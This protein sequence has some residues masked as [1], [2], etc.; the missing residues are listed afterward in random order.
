MGGQL[1]FT[2][3]R[4]AALMVNHPY[5]PF[6][7]T[8]HVTVTPVAGMMLTFPSFLY[9]EVTAYEGDTPRISIAFNMR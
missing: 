1:I 8:N 5:N 4:T 3:P 7:A 9:H 6:G 2:D